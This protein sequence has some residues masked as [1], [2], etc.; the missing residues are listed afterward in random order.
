VPRNVVTLTPRVLTLPTRR[1]RETRQRIE[2]IVAER[3]RARVENDAERIEMDF[4]KAYGWPS[5]RAQ[6]KDA[7]RDQSSANP[8]IAL[9]E[10]STPRSSVALRDR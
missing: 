4:R 1:N 2:Q 3:Y 7:G 8:N 10:A 9:T 6:P 5:R